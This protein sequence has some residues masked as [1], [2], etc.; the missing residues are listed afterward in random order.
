MELIPST[1]VL[2]PPDGG[3]AEVG[4]ALTVR[5]DTNG[6]ET[7]P[8]VDRQEGDGLEVCLLSFPGPT[9][10]GLGGGAPVFIYMEV[11]SRW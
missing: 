4:M 11:H 1:V 2:E 3:V 9:T 6:A 7:F 10:V 8:T 5:Y